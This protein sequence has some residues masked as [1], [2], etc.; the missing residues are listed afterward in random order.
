MNLDLDNGKTDTK[1]DYCQ[2]VSS[3]VSLLGTCGHFSSSATGEENRLSC[4]NVKCVSVGR[5]AISEMARRGQHS[6]SYGRTWLF[7]EA[8]RATSNPKVMGTSDTERKGV[9]F[10][11]T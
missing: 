7:G 8:V 6:G 2:W 4:L 9:A 5:S 1:D 3:S 11:G 10:S